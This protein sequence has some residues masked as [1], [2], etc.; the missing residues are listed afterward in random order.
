MP[1]PK[2][3]PKAIQKAL[4][5]PFV[6]GLEII[7]VT[8]YAITVNLHGGKP[9]PLLDVNGFRSLSSWLQAIQ[10]FLLGALPLWMY[11]TYR[12]PEVPP[13]RNLLAFTALL[14]LF[15]STDELFKFN[16]LFHQHQLWQVIYISFGIALPLLFRRD[17]A[18]L[19][20]LDPNA[21]RLIVV[22]II[23][24][25]LGGFGLELFR[26]YVQEPYWY[27]LF[28]RW[29]FYQVDA[30]RTAFEEFGELLGATLLLKGMV[31]L[32]QQ[33]QTALAA[34]LTDA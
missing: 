4:W 11:L 23:I 32:A 8:L 10:L 17:L 29:Q 27:Q 12:H 20:Q 19:G 26:R 14:F 6:I 25:V 5:V 3:L 9:Y 24:F 31:S 16:F 7:L 15:A 18:R 13:S 30:V 28:G 21:M 2:A 33:R 22:G 34:R 1:L